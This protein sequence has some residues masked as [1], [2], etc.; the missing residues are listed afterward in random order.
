MSMARILGCIVISHF[1]NWAKPKKT[2]YTDKLLLIKQYQ[3]HE[4]ILVT[5]SDFSSL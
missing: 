5:E 4:I 1:P 2:L 3:Y